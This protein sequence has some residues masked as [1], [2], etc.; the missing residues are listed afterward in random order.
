MHPQKE[1]LSLNIVLVEDHDA[2]RTL[3]CESLN[4]RG[5]LVHGL[6]C[7]EEL[8][9]FQSEGA[10]DL[11]LLDLNLPGEDGL[12]LAR[13]LRSVDPAVGII[14][15]TARSTARDRIAG[16]DSG[17]DLYINKPFEIEELV[18]AIGAVG[19]RHGTLSVDGGSP[20]EGHKS[21]SLDQREFLLSSGAGDKQVGL[22]ESEVRT[23]VAFARAPAQRLS[24]EQI[25]QLSGVDP[26]T[27]VSKSNV[28]VRIAR[29]RKKL[30]SIGAPSQALTSI[31]NGGYQLCISI[32]LR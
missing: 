17:A 10:T 25:S 23:L 18:A 28:E 12:S 16:Y 7:A 24:V 3:V 14:M 30:L 1:S 31:R 5:H 29:L 2:L 6:S 22:T 4:E 9:A 27:T 32:T 8:G 26:L 15:V 19:R 21:Y 20:D 13:R 11:F